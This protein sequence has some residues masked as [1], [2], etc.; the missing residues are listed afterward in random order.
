MA[1][2][3][4][5]P[6]AEQLQD[7]L[8]ESPGFTEFLLGLTAISASLLGGETPLLCAITVERETGPVTVASS[9]ETARSLDERQYAFDDGPCLTALR[10]Q[11]TV[12]I[13]DLQADESWAW[14]A[15]AVADEGI[16]TILAV[17]IPTDNGSRSALNCYSTQLN[18]FAPD[19]V[20]AIE[21]H[22]ASL[23][24]ILRLA[25][26]VHPSDPY[27]DHLRSALRS[28]AVVDSAV[29][30]IMVQNR[31]SHEAAVKLLHL[32]SRSSNR[33]LHDI[34]GDILHH[35]SD[36]PVITGGGEK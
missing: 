20:T 10:E 7:L 19:T 13:R 12:L 31:C 15:G 22:A 17:P 18:T 26:R 35:A 2:N 14:Y 24:R 33:R 3:D 27:P 36:I 23:S 4:A 21:E 1:E 5:L 8:L 6:T 9:T 28:R 32:A 25:I 29:A 30:L 11:R 16:R 34:A